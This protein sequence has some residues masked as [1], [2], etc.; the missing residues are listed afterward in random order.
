[1][2]TQYCQSCGSALDAGST[3]C[4]NCGKSA[5]V[6]PEQP[7]QPAQN[8]S[9]SYSAPSSTYTAPQPQPQPTYQTVPPNYQT[10]YQAS[11][12]QSLAIDKPLSIMD[13]IVMFIV[14]SL[15]LVGFI[16]TLVWAFGSDTNTNKKN[17]CR[18]YL[19]LA[20]IGIGLTIIFAIVFGAILVPVLTEMFSSGD[21]SMY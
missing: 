17:Y 9:Q 8:S 1:M 12:Q 19:I 6:T 21:F 2:S 18:A 7:S 3:F 11:T 14:M 15:P 4:S 16:M 13:Y 20:L 5:M 10:G